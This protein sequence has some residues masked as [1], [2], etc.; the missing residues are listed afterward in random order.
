MTGTVPLHM[1]EPLVSVIIRTFKR[2][3]VLAQAINSVIA[4]SY[5]NIE[6]IVAEDGADTARQ[7]VSSYKAPFPV[8]YICSGKNIRRSNNGNRALAAA[9]GTYIN[10]LDD[11]DLLLPEHISLLVAQAEKGNYDLVHAPAFCSRISVDSTDPYEYTE[12][13]RTLEHDVPFTKADLFQN[14][15]FPI[16][17]VLF[18]RSLYEKYGGFDPALDYLEDWDLW[19]K[20]CQNSSVGFVT[21][22]TS[23]YHVPAV[24]TEELQRQKLL[25]STRNDVLSRYSAT[26][27]HVE[28]IQSGS[29]SH[30]SQSA[31]EASRVKIAFD[32][33][34]RTRNGIEIQGWALY[35]GSAPFDT[36][37]LLS[38]NHS[39]R[40]HSTVR[41]DIAHQTGSSG[42]SFGFSG[43]IDHPGKNLRLLFTD[44]EKT[45]ELPLLPMV[46]IKH[47][48]RAFARK[49]LR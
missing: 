6:L 34:N 24:K 42:N 40:L 27:L 36:V 19:L 13:E 37:F 29:I 35:N 4:Q 45:Y 10:F 32:T 20:Y 21:L 7:L 44:E 14:N 30:G 41:K 11:D 31:L 48:L 3:A 46:F 38:D 43:R 25:G 47:R 39:F 5:R 18:K 33:L 9:T 12:A 28:E 26:Y 17:A 15:L 8:V 2:P 22:P 49:M 1:E 16:Q 23:V